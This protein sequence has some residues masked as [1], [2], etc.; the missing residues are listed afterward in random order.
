M[1][2]R[3]VNPPQSLQI[4]LPIFLILPR[5]Q[6]G[7]DSIFIIFLASLNI[8]FNVTLNKTMILNTSLVFIIKSSSTMSFSLFLVQLTYLITYTK[9]LQIWIVISVFL[10][11]FLLKCVLTNGSFPIFYSNDLNNIYLIKVS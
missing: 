11:F 1:K 9:K 8:S 7:R 10:P 5:T 3:Y 2:K 6:S 4:N